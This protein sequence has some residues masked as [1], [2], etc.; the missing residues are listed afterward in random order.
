LRV[1]L[2]FFVS[3]CLD[4]GARHCTETDEE[5]DRG[6]TK[7]KHPKDSLVSIDTC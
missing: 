3:K 2:S 5:I 6:V 7:G 4:K 1:A